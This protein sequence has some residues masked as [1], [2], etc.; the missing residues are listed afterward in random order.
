MAFF[1]DHCQEMDCLFAQYEQT[2]AKRTTTL[3]NKQRCYEVEER[4]WAL[5]DVAFQRMLGNASG[6]RAMDDKEEKGV[7]YEG[8]EVKRRLANKQHCH[9]AAERNKALAAKAL[10]EEQRCQEEAV[11]A[12]ALADE[13]HERRGWE[14]ATC[15]MV[16]AAK[17]RHHDAA[18]RATTLATALVMMPSALTTAVLSS[19]PRPTT[20]VGAVLFNMGGKAHVPPVVVASLPLPSA[21]NGHFGMVCCCASPRHRTGQ[22]N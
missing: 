16:M 13:A 5:E 20:Y 8:Q 22:C 21:A 3:A 18:K 7:E 19:P 12:K 6:L 10:A 15:A 11:R 1:A 4:E 17:E 2:A 14:D 9:K